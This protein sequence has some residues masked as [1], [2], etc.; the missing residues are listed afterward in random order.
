VVSSADT[1]PP[2]ADAPTQSARHRVAFLA[3]GLRVKRKS[4]SRKHFAVRCAAAAGASADA[5]VFLA[6]PRQARG[7]TASSLNQAHSTTASQ[8]PP[9]GAIDGAESGVIALRGRYTARILAMT[10]SWCTTTL[11]I[12]EDPCAETPARCCVRTAAS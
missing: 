12:V 8:I 1:L 4:T 2:L 5:A 10:K 11:R 3:T 7:C 6:M 9:R